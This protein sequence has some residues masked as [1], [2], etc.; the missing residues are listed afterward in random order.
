MPDIA[1]VSPASQSELRP[2]AQLGVTVAELIE[3]LPQGWLQA[4][5]V[6]DDAHLP[7]EQ[8]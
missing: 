4:W 7:I 1:I 5:L 3:Q 2:P 8:E 6:T